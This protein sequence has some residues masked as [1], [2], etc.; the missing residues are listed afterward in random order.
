VFLKAQ[1]HGSSRTSDHLGAI[2]NP[3]AG[4]WRIAQR[5]VNVARETRRK[6]RSHVAVDPKIIEEWAN[7]NG[8]QTAAS[9]ETQL[10]AADELLAAFN[11]LPVPTQRAIVRSR[12][13]GW[14]LEAIAREL[15]VSTHK[16]EKHITRALAHFTALSRAKSASRKESLK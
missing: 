8:F 10:E 13:D 5:V 7:R 14:S 3:R 1:G 12:R 15:G 11:K 4:L 16:V 6:A 9:A 2:L